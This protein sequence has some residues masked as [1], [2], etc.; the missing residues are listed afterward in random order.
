MEHQQKALMKLKENFSCTAPAN[1][2]VISMPTGSGKTAILLLTPYL[3]DAKKALVIVPSLSLYH[4]LV[5]DALGTKD[6]KGVVTT[7]LKRIGVFPDI[8]LNEYPSVEEVYSVDK[9]EERKFANKDLVIANVGKFHTG[10]RSKWREQLPKDMFDVVIIDEAHHLSSD[11]WKNIVDHFGCDS[12]VLFLTA[13]PYR[14]DGA[15]ILQMF[16][17]GRLLYHYPLGLIPVR[18]AEKWV[19]FLSINLLFIFTQCSF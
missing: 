18:M 17:K 16:P 15:S 6:D 19:Q 7:S 8:P 14:A 5:D 13:T 12:K 2:A 11:S 4:Q 3:L 1:P 10:S 9:I